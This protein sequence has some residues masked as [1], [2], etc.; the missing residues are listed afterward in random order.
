MASGYPKLRCQGDAFLR[1]SVR[2]QNE[3]TTNKCTAIQPRQCYQCSENP[4]EA[5]VW[6]VLP[7]AIRLLRTVWY[8]FFIAST[9]S[10]TQHDVLSPLIDQQQISE[11]KRHRG[12][13]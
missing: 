2:K 4:K 10:L 9:F 5:A 6:S 3:K 13:F 12:S 8:S 11:I 1:I 7:R